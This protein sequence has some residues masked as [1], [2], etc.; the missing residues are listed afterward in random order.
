MQELIISELFFPG[1]R[2]FQLVNYFQNK[3]NATVFQ[4]TASVLRL[5]DVAQHAAIC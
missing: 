5:K 2:P 1:K 3:R 4:S